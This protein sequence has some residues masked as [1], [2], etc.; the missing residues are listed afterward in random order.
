MPAPHWEVRRF[1]TLPSTNAYLLAEARAGGA[2]GLVAVA[3]HQTAGRGRLGRRWESPP[4]RSLLASV[5]LRPVVAPDRLFCCT[6]AVALATIEAC[7][8]V[9]GCVAQ[10]KWPNDLVVADAKLAG[11]LAEADPGAP[12]GPDG[13]VAVVVGVGCNIDWAGPDGVQATSLAE[14][15]GR[16]V[17]RDVLLEAL[18]D[19]LGPLVASLG[20]GTGQAAIVAELKRHSA[21]LGRP[22][23]VE[24]A[25][26]PG[27]TRVIEGRA[28][29]LSPDGHLLVEAPGGPVAVSAG[30]VIHLRPG[31]PGTVK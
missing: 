5:L 25:T 19:F 31:G 8:A 11:V 12:G 3:D 24:L 4:G 22:V 27:A 13:S 14:E 2:E 18:L 17:E 10:V 7:A 20:T 1:E 16:P 21:T 15:T 6:G 28:L 26:G 9:A 30:D 29:D 23:R